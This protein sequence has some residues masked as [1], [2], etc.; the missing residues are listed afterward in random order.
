MAR[1]SSIL[2]S[3]E[4]KPVLEVFR[5]LL[6]TTTSVGTTAIPIPATNLSNRKAILIQ[7]LSSTANV[8]IGGAIAE[9]L[10]WQGSP[11]INVYEPKKIIVWKKSTTGNEWY[12][13]NPNGGNA[14][15]TQPVRI[16]SGSTVGSETDRGVAETVALLSATNKW[17]WGDG[18][19]LGF[20]TLY[21]RTAGATAAYAPDKVYESI[22]TYSRVPEN[23]TGTYGYLLGPSDAVSF[24]LDGSVIVWAIA[25]ATANV[26][27]L[28]FI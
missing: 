14:S 18:D 5:G 4:A 9:V 28:E 17:G 8:Y 2:V 22:L 11:P 3:K 21:I 27:T 19:S 24:T 16:L 1:L 6:H 15:L 12:A 7:N 13:T 26:L 23:N 25:S 10:L 20:S